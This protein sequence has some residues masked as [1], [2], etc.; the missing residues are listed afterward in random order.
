MPIQLRPR[1]AT[2]D[3]V[4]LLRECHE[5]IRRFLILARR[6]AT[7][8]DATDDEIRR[9]AGDIRQYFAES[10]AMHVADES[11]H[12]VPR[13]ASSGAD[14]QAAVAQLHSDHAAHEPLVARLVELCASIER[15]PQRLATT[16][17]VLAYLTVRLAIELEAHLELEE[18]SIFPAVRKLPRHELDAILV[19]MRARR[20]TALQL[21]P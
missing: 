13:I 7:V 11:E 19:N 2:P 15:E 14:M 4:D 21:E 3:V 20:R 6:L 17:S 18:R 12:I 5:R 10:F 8:R 9:L 16:A 1:G